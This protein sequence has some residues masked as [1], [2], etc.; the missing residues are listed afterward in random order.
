MSWGFTTFVY[1][2]FNFRLNNERCEKELE[3]LCGCATLN[4]I[5]PRKVDQIFTKVKRKLDLSR[6]TNS[7]A[8]KQFVIIPYDKLNNTIANR[9]R[10]LDIKVGFSVQ[11]TLAS[12]L[13]SMKDKLDV[14][15]KSWVYRATCGDCDQVYT[16]Q[17]R[18]AFRTRSKVHLHNPQISNFCKHLLVNDHDP[19]KAEFKILTVDDKFHRIN[20]RESVEIHK[21]IKQFPGCIINEQLGPCTGS[22]IKWL[23]K[24]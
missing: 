24:V 6:L 1:R 7:S 13:P 20:V 23:D 4:G 19:Q 14:E 21:F 9:F 17:T 18:R 16:G 10:K 3:F 15:W 11:D 12:K 5:N 8:K 22:L 2:I